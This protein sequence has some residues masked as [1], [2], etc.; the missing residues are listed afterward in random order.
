MI[1]KI[2]LSEMGL[3]SIELNQLFATYLTPS[4]RQPAL[5]II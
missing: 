2:L 1:R 4:H 5:M 3:V